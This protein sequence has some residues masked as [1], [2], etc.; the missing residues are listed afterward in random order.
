MIKIISKEFFSEN[1]V[2]LEIYA[3]PIAQARRVGH[4]VTV[5]VV[6]KGERFPLTISSA[7]PAKGRN[8]TGG[9]AV[10]MKFAAEVTRKSKRFDNIR[11]IAQTSKLKTQNKSIL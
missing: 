7:Y 8:N 1:V 9:T 2:S 6:E 5:R 11:R 10:M 4:F 3:L